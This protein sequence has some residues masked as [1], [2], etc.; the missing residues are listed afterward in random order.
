MYI[1]DVPTQEYY[2]CIGYLPGLQKIGMT[3]TV[4]GGYIK[5]SRDP[6]DC[7]HSQFGQFAR[8]CIT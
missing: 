4:R 5:F 7:F 3:R 2:T 6:R 1:V 8:P